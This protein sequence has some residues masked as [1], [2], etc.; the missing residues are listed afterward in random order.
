MPR[1]WGCC[2]H[3]AELPH[4]GVATV[5][6]NTGSPGNLIVKVTQVSASE[7]GRQGF[8][9]SQHCANVSG[10]LRNGSAGLECRPS[11]VL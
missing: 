3:T 1:F 10:R 5:M 7:A 11:A 4:A 6:A 8:C 9:G 2:S